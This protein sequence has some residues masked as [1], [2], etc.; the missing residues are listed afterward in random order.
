MTLGRKGWLFVGMVHLLIPTIAMFVAV[1]ATPTPCTTPHD[2]TEAYQITSIIGG[3]LYSATGAINVALLA[4]DAKLSPRMAYTNSIMAW[5]SLFFGP[6]IS[7]VHLAP[8]C[9]LFDYGRWYATPNFG[10]GV[11]WGLQ[12][13][14]PAGPTWRAVV[15]MSLSIASY[16]LAFAFDDPNTGFYLAFGPQVAGAIIMCVLC[17]RRYRSAAAARAL[18][19]WVSACGCFLLLNVLPGLPPVVKTALIQVCDNT[20]IHFSIRFFV[21]M[22]RMKHGGEMHQGAGVAPHQFSEAPLGQ[23]LQCGEVPAAPTTAEQL[24]ESGQHT[25]DAATATQPPGKAVLA[26]EVSPAAWAGSCWR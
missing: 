25:G 9:F 11:E 21:C 17:F 5:S 13:L 1:V 15:I 26:E 22:F 7:Y 4:T 2:R 24:L 18:V 23:Q 20:Q 3:V 12:L 16:F 8:Q 19:M 14:G 6:A 10:W